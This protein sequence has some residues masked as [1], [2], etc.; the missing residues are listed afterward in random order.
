MLG[1]GLTLMCLRALQANREWKERLLRFSFRTMTGGLMVMIVQSLLPVG[2]LPSVAS[3]TH[4][5]WYS[6]S[7]EFLG[8][9]LIQ[10]RRLLRMPGD[11][12][13][14]IGAIGFVVSIFGLGFGYF[15]RGQRTVCGRGRGPVGLRAIGST[16]R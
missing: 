14:A 1:L 11:T 2:P 8:Q 6:R 7:G 12:L 3:V 13:F 9:G 4:G 10:T 5:Y 15:H 16:G